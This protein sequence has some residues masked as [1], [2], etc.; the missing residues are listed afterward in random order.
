MMIGR[1]GIAVFGGAVV[2]LLASAAVSAAPSAH[3]SDAVAPAASTTKAV[4]ARAIAPLMARYGIP[5]MAVGI[6]IDGRTSVFSYGVAS[7]ATGAP[8]D[9]NTLFEIGSV[10]KTFT[11]T[12]AGYARITGKLALSDIASADDPTL[13]G[14]GFDRVTLLDLATYTAGGL[15]L[16][17][18]DGVTTDAQLRAYLRAWQPRYPPGT[19]RLYSNVS[20]GVLGAIVA[21]R[22]NGRFDR[23]VERDIFAPLGMRASYYAIPPAEQTQYAQGYTFDDKP[24][25]LVE[26]PLA[27]PTYG[28]RTTT[29]SLLRFIQANLNAMRNGSP[30]QRAMVAAR[31]GYYHVGPIVQGLVWERVDCPLDRAHLR[32]ANSDHILFDPNPARRLSPPQSPRSDALFDKTGST[33]GFSAYVAFV[34]QTHAGIILLAN[35]SYPMTARIDAAYAIL[36]GLNALPQCGQHG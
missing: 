31:T 4:A 19:Q 27:A 8:V 1:R 7:K 14:S 5:G 15:P 22:L 16:Q 26:G 3:G 24:I 35:K 18:P 32:A 28:V 10:S 12:L 34:P 23:L 33:N 25:R 30:L 20:I 21:H 6:T 13:R 36:K 17:V 9:G 29:G 11:A 2:L